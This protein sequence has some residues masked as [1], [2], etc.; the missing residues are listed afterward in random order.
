MKIRYD[1]LWN[2]VVLK[3]PLL[4]PMIEK[5]FEQMFNF[6]FSPMLHRQHY[7]KPNNWIFAKDHKMPGLGTT[8]CDKLFFIL[9][10]VPSE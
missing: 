6:V 1:L 7:N 9:R 3:R 5:I 8:T 10:K 2:S 4:S